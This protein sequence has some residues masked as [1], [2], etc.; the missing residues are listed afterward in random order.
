MDY[1]DRAVAYLTERPSSIFAAWLRHDTHPCGRLFAISSVSRRPETLAFDGERSCGCLTAIRNTPETYAAPSE[2]LTLAIMA[3][4]RLPG[5]PLHLGLEHLPAFAEWQRRLD[6]ELNRTPP[7]WPT[8]P[9]RKRTMYTEVPFENLQ[10]G[11]RVR[12]TCGDNLTQE[13]EFLCFAPECNGFL[14]GVPTNDVSVRG[15]DIMDV[16]DYSFREVRR[17]ERLA[18]AECRGK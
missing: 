17:I 7:V 5:N 11:D 3:D 9:S 12:V 16:V 1:Y 4:E 2:E 15:I 10:T 14:V 6:K 13:G 8:P 18:A